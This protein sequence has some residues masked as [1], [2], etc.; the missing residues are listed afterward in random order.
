MLVY[1]DVL[2][3]AITEREKEANREFLPTGSLPK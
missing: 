3:A 1:S 2:N